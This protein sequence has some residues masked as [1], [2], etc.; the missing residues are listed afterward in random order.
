MIVLILLP[1]IIEATRETKETL[2]I[3]KSDCHVI[4]L[5]LSWKVLNHLPTRVQAKL[6]TKRTFVD[7][8]Q[9][10]ATLSATSVAI[11]GTV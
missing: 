4:V 9:G 5:N 7:I 3:D 2:L 11:K 10:I 6:L 8:F 1:R